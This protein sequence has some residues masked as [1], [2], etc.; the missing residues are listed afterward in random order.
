MVT[1][2]ELAKGLKAAFQSKDYITCEKLLTPTKIELIKANLLIPDFGKLSSGNTAYINDLEI[3]KKILEIGALSSINLLAFSSFENYYA[4]LRVF[5]FDHTASAIFGESENKKKL[6][7]LY[8]L[9]LLSQGDVTRFHSELEYLSKRNLGN[10]DENTYLSYPIK[11]E[12]LLMEGSYQKAWDMLQ[13]DKGDNKIEE[14]NIFDETLMNAIRESI[15]SN[16]EVAYTRLPLI[17]LKALLFF[18]TEKQTAAFAEARGWTLANGNVVFDEDD[19]VD[20]KEETVIVTKAL[21]YAINL[22]SIV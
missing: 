7:S 19:V 17:N 2:P 13:N 11:L 8:L 20:K 18:K 12:K 16:T 6:I 4:Q 14:F 3:A 10:L 21:E 9:I 5:Y 15:A 22:E 1:L